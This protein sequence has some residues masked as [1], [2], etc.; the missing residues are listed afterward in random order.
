MPPTFWPILTKFVFFLAAFLYVANI[1][2]DEKTS[3]GS[4]NITCGEKDGWIAGY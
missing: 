3:S 1:K 2:F 4:R